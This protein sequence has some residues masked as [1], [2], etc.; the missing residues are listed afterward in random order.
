MNCLPFYIS[1]KY[2][3][4]WPDELSTTQHLYHAQFPNYHFYFIFPSA[5]FASPMSFKTFGSWEGLFSTDPICSF[6]FSSILLSSKRSDKPQPLSHHLLYCTYPSKLETNMEM[7]SIHL[8]HITSPLLSG[9][10]SK[11]QLYVLLSIEEASQ[12]L[13]QLAYNIVLYVLLSGIAI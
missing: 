9:Q 7:A 13:L 2:S 11:L 1:S 8:H 12:F 6:S 3:P 4:I 10:T 5:L